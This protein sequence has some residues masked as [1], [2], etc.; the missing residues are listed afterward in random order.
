MSYSV[1]VRYNKLA[2]LWKQTN[3]SLPPAQFSYLAYVPFVAYHSCPYC[4]SCCRFYYTILL[5]GTC[6]S[7][8]VVNIRRRRGR[9]DWLKGK[10][11]KARWLD[12][13]QRSGAI[14]MTV[15][16]LTARE[17]GAKKA[18]SADTLLR[19]SASRH[20]YASLHF[21]IISGQHPMCV[22]RA[23]RICLLSNS[24]CT[25]WTA[26]DDSDEAC[27]KSGRAVAIVVGQLAQLVAYPSSIRYELQA[28]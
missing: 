18:L 27:R 16:D 12:G 13:D 6:T 21:W 25:G 19:M 5:S 1:S 10:R 7:L 15:R 14:I 9:A 2:L 26:S 3:L 24:N 11:T 22:L 17:N 8:D 4:C 28:S 23:C 20:F